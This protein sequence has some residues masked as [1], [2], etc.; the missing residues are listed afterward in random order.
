MPLLDLGQTSLKGL[1]RLGLSNFELLQCMMAVVFLLHAADGAMLPA[2]F[3]AMEEEVHGAT[4]VSLGVIV[5]A[6][7]LCHSLAVFAWGVLADRRCKLYLLQYATLAWGILTLATAFVHG[8]GSLAT[9]RALA[10]IVGA[11]LGP[12]SQG[13]IGAVCPA[14]KRGRAFGFLIACGQAGHIFGLL[15]AGST[16]HLRI[17]GGWRGSFILFSLLTIVL[18]WVLA[19][20]R[21]EVSEG[22][23]AESRTWQRLAA[24]RTAD[25]GSY[26]EVAWEVAQNF[27]V[28]VQRRSFL[29]LILQGAF[30]STTVKAM[31][32]QVMWYQY[33]GFSDFV[34]SAVTS[35][36]PLG[37]I[38]GA[39]ASG[40][41]SDSLA[42]RFPDHGRIALGQVADTAKLLI[43]VLIF[44][45]CR[46]SLGNDTGTVAMMTGLTLS[47][48]FVSIMAYS[49]V[50]KPL[51][52]EIVPPNMIAQVIGIAAAI[53]GA[54]SSFASAPVVGYIT[55]YVFNY[56]ET[57]LPI[58]DMPEHLRVKNARALGRSIAVVTVIS[59]VLTVLFF[60]FLH[61]TYP[62]DREA[63]RDAA[64][65]STGAT[66]HEATVQACD[67]ASTSSEFSSDRSSSG[68]GRSAI[69]GSGAAPRSSRRVEFRI[70]YGT[71]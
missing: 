18:A 30:A 42:R 49:A 27:S 6:E 36:A 64:E 15:L 71:A 31:Q 40:Y 21:T 16:S 12:L 65:V 14:N 48:G 66:F 22:L 44:L 17:I 8:I 43:L 47:F 29:V 41:I 58:A 67:G 13:L 34:A 19:Q 11:A 54:F 1:A 37:C 39:I 5:L 52:A 7:A 55:Q 9:I 25:K 26:S 35:A 33:L 61:F 50:V 10:G 68:G 38:G 28:I 59:T 24:E 23:F 51:F 4:P 32:Y 69:Q 20:V 57:T 2:V 56:H 62:R 46:S 53:D 63:S 60:S 3:K 70:D 45:S